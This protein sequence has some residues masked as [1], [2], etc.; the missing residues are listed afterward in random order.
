MTSAH[1]TPDVAVACACTLGESPVW[2]GA[3]QAL[4]WVDLRAPALHRLDAA[5]G[6]TTDL[7]DARADRC[8]RA[9]R[10]GRPAG[11]AA[12][13]HPCVRPAHRGVHAARRARAGR[14]GTSAERDEGG[15]HRP[16]V[17][18]HDARLRPHRDRLALSHRRRPRA[19]PRAR[20]HPRAE[21]A[22]LEPRR[23]D[24]VLR[25]HARRPA[26]RLCVGSRQRRARR[27]ARAGRRRRAAR[28][29]RR[30]DRR[31]GRVRVECALRR[32][33][34]RAHHAGRRDRPRGPDAGAQRHLVRARRSRTFARCTSPPRASG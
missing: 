1:D 21:R 3:E 7:A 6:A 29:A 20:R 26:A 34:R 4:Y 18:L 32:R 10:A 16:P 9:A 30:R 13:R 12:E 27:D 14:D 8:G 2:S 15:S 24:D 11:R 33:R 17:D 5:T 23:R 19:A 25:R 31:C 22:V 28:R